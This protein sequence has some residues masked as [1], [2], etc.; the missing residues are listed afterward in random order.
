MPDLCSAQTTDKDRQQFEKLESDLRKD[1]D[2][3]IG[4]FKPYKGQAKIS[5]QEP[6][7]NLI[8]SYDKFKDE[9]TV[10][11]AMPLYRGITPPHT[12]A[13][14][15]IKY[16]GD[17][18]VYA[19]YSFPGQQPVKP[20]SIYLLF[21]SMADTSTFG[22]NPSLIFLAD[23]KRMKIGNMIQKV[24]S[25]G[26][27][28]KETETAAMSFDNFVAIANADIVEVQVSQSAFPLSEF[29]LRGFRMLAGLPSKEPRP[30]MPKLKTAMVTDLSSS[31]VEG[32]SW[33]GAGLS[34]EFKVGGELLLQGGLP[35]RAGSWK[36]IGD[37]VEIELPYVDI[38][39]VRCIGVGIVKGNKMAMKIKFIN[40]FG[41]SM[42]T[43]MEFTP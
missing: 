15:D 9:T 10:S 7:L 12:G 43:V 14:G 5:F 35:N 16:I 17:I 27:L 40:V 36:Q 25:Y 39:A 21:E 2:K 30:A 18:D 13:V 4:K 6:T 34:A 1:L 32:T 31:R 19:I 29:H 20:Q 26:T 24:R 8:T 3:E 11:I 38:R 22:A 42:T 28:I 23:D 41:S 33:R 37:R